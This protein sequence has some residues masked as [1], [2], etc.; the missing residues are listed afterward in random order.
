VRLLPATTRGRVLTLAIIVGL[1]LAAWRYQSKLIGMAAE[2]YLTRVAAKDEARGEIGGRRQLLEQ[3]HRRL[4]MPAPPEAFVPELFDFATVLSSRVAN[5]DVSLNWAAYLY[6]N[7][8]RQ[9][10][11]ERPSGTPRRSKDELQ[12][13]LDRQVEFFAIRKRPDVPGV[14]VG[15]LLGADGDS[16]SLEEIEAAEREG[17][18]LDLR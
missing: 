17:R 10:G 2:R 18:E 8:W 12:A 16:I 14:R 9:L 6:T 4:L 1:A 15:D 13:I 7:Y 5:G 3:I 11:Q